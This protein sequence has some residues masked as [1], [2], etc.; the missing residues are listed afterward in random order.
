MRMC[1]FAYERL[2]SNDSN[3]LGCWK[4]AFDQIQRLP[5]HTQAHMQ[6]LVFQQ[7]NKTHSKR[8][9]V[10]SVSIN[11]D[12]HSHSNWVFH[13]RMKFIWMI[14][15]LRANPHHY[16]TK[17]FIP[18]LVL[19][20]FTFF[21]HSFVHSLIRSLAH[22]FACSFVCLICCV[23]NAMWLCDTAVVVVVRGSVLMF[24]CCCRLQP[25]PLLFATTP[26][27]RIRIRVQSMADIEVERCGFL[28]LIRKKLLTRSLRSVLPIHSVSY[29]STVT[30]CWHF[31]HNSCFSVV[32]LH[33]H[34]PRF[35]HTYFSIHS[36]YGR[37][38]F[39]S[40]AQ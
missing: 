19:L 33:F 25:L 6:M 11:E 26:H 40:S 34:A 27:I 10:W 8:A 16:S 29:I 17:D 23:Y 32:C 2:H 5:L 37:A 15:L 3:W 7:T 18:V 38:V 39:I 28:L 22:S 21:N 35:A 1:V 9:I 14:S 36:C 20:L 4:R 13:S 30:V 12:K 31:S 24:C